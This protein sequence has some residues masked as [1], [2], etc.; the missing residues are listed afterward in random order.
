MVLKSYN[1]W[2]LKLYSCL[3]EEQ[4]VVH[5]E[6]G[7]QELQQLAAKALQLYN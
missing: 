7:S 5:T 3:P 1:S 6:Y 2:L 4:A